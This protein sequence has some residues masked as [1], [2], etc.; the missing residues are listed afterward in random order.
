MPTSLL[1]HYSPDS[2]NAGGTYYVALRIFLLMHSH[3]IS[4]LVLVALFNAPFTVLLKS[5]S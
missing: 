5:Q 4:L 3:F 2:D 1:L